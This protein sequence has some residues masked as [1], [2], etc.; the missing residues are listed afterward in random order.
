[1]GEWVGRLVVSS[2]TCTLIVGC[3]VEQ[4][5]QVSVGRSVSQSVEV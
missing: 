1:M 5:V 2:T 4:A 3:C